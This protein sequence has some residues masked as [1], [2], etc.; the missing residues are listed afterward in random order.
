MTDQRLFIAID[1]PGSVRRML[2]GCA[3]EGGVKPTDE[4]NLHLTLHF[5]GMAEPSPIIDLLDG[6][7]CSIEPF[8]LSIEGVGYFRGRGRSLIL[9]AG[10]VL[11][12]PLRQLYDELAGCLSA[13][14]LQVD[15]R[16]YSPHITIARGTSRNDIDVHRFVSEHAALNAHCHVEA[17]VLYSSLAGGK[18]R[19][20]QPLHVRSLGRDR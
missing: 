3:P 9:W 12:P 16:P 19:I 11:T 7:N 14:G 4:N 1:L 8:D 18:G 2:R 20:Y 10:V 13:A 6:W 15:A 17:V 5:L